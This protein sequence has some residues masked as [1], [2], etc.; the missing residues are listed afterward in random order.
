MSREWTIVNLTRKLLAGSATPE[1]RALVD[2]LC[3]QVEEERRDFADGVQLLLELDPERNRAANSTFDLEVGSQRSSGALPSQACMQVI[4]ACSTNTHT[5]V[6]VWHTIC[7]AHVE[8]VGRPLVEQ[9]SCRRL[10][11]SRWQSLDQTQL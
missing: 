4:G 5:R 1:D 3:N 9:N 10:I 2:V 8:H 11:C 6:C 7:V